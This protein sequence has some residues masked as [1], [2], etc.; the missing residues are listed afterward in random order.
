MKQTREKLKL[1]FDVKTFISI[2]VTIGSIS[3]WGS[4]IINKIDTMAINQE[5]QGKVIEELIV[6]RDS[7]HKVI[8]TKLTRL[9]TTVIILKDKLWI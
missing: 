2:L 3:F 4:N 7:D 9:E 8:D 6:K 5:K 1:T